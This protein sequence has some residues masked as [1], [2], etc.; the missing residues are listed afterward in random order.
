MT[1]KFKKID[2]GR[3]RRTIDS[4]L[5]NTRR[6]FINET[7]GLLKNN[8]LRVA[9]IRG[10][11]D[12]ANIFLSGSLCGL[13]LLYCVFI[14]QNRNIEND[15]IRFILPITRI[16]YFFTMLLLSFSIEKYTFARKGH[17]RA[18]ET[19]DQLNIILLRKESIKGMIIMILQIITFILM[20]SAT[21]LSSFIIIDRSYIDP[22]IIILLAVF[23]LQELSWIILGCLQTSYRDDSRIEEM[24]N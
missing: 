20:L 4:I 3:A 19:G 9:K 7:E 21:R 8:D 1:R 2:E 5:K 13:F 17:Q 12:R 10:I 11:I 15:T 18:I 6:T 24:I 14:I 16:L 23:F 22:Y